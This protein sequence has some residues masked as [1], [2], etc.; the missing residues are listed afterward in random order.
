VNCEKQ[1]ELPKKGKLPAI[2]QTGAYTFGCLLNGEIFIPRNLFSTSLS[3]SYDS[4]SGYLRINA[5]YSWNFP[6]VN[7]ELVIDEG[8]FSEGLYS[9]GDGFEY[10]IKKTSSKETESIIYRIDTMSSHFIENTRFDLDSNIVSGLFGFT[11]ISEDLSDTI[12]VLNG[13]FDLKDV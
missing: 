12:L 7:I 4:Y 13:R 11:A 8:L 9:L 5:D 10:D 1:P 6:H 2:T 3:M